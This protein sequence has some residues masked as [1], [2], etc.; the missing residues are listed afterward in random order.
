MHDV[1]DLSVLKI[2]ISLFSDVFLF[3][4]KSDFIASFFLRFPLCISSL[5]EIDNAVT[6]CYMGEQEIQC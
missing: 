3:F 6:I 5:F 2:D 4:L 1:F